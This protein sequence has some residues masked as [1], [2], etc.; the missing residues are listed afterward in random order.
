MFYDAHFIPQAMPPVLFS[1][2]LKAQPTPHQSGSPRSLSDAA[3]TS[4]VDAGVVAQGVQ[5]YYECPVYKTAARAG[6]LSTTGISTNYVLTVQLRT[7]QAPAH[8]VGRGVA[9]LCTLDE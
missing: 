8:W 5:H 1:S 2:R 6:T 9:L 4:V 7:E 3:G